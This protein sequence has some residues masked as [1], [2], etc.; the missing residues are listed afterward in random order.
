[1][2]L[3]YRDNVISVIDNYIKYMNYYNDNKDMIEKTILSLNKCKENIKKA[4][5]A[6]TNLAIEY[7]N[8]IVCGLFGTVRVIGRNE[9]NL[10][11]KCLSTLEDC[12]KKWSLDDGS[13]DG[14]PNAKYMSIEALY[15]MLGVDN[16]FRYY[17]LNNDKKVLLD[18]QNKINTTNIELDNRAKELNE[19]LPKISFEYPE[20]K[21]DIELE[22]ELAKARIKAFKDLNAEIDRLLVIIYNEDMYIKCVAN[23][24]IPTVITNIYNGNNVDKSLLEIKKLHDN[25]DIYRNKELATASSISNSIGSYKE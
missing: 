19:K 1:M 11:D 20:L 22:L 21:R 6:N 2:E 25:I 8:N 7:A 10:V 13:R 5:V 9:N 3:N 18:T 17:R 24:D 16:I 23:I 15:G 4:T 14:D 12:S